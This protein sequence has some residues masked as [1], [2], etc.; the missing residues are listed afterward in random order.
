MTNP[1]SSGVKMGRFI[2]GVINDRIKSARS[3]E[4]AFDPTKMNPF[5]KATS[6]KEDEEREEYKERKKKERIKKDNYYK[7]LYGKDYKLYRDGSSPE[8][9]YKV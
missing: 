7:T 6:W 1:Y 2:N 5:E 4:L 9:K 3:T 8:W